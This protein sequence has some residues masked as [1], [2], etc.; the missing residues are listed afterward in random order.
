MEA[1]Q[2]HLALDLLLGGKALDTPL[3]WTD[4]GW[5]TRATWTNALAGEVWGYGYN[6]DGTL[7]A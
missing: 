6:D 1:P 5:A 7:N 4:D 3:C 2:P